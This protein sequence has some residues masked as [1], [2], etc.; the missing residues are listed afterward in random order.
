MLKGL[1]V[2]EQEGQRQKETDAV[3]TLK[4]KKAQ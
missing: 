1:Y 4:K 3:K 2:G